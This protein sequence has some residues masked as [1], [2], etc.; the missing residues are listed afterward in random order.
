MSKAETTFQIEIPESLR[1]DFAGADRAL[2]SAVAARDKLLVKQAEQKAAMKKE[3]AAATSEVAKAKRR[4][5]AI[6]NRA[7][8]MDLHRQAGQQALFEDKGEEGQAGDE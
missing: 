5:H 6:V 3:L 7:V 2:G 4:R 8:T 1:A